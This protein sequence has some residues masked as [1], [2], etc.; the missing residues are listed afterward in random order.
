MQ[1]AVQQAFRAPR[2]SQM[3]SHMN[4]C[5]GDTYAREGAGD[6]FVDVDTG[7]DDAFA[8]S[9]AAAMQCAGKARL[10]GVSSVFGNASERNTFANTCAVLSACNMHSVRVHRGARAPLAWTR[11]R[12]PAEA[13]H[14]AG[15]LGNV[16][17]LQSLRPDHN[18]ITS[19]S[20]NALPAALAIAQAAEKVYNQSTGGK[21]LTVMCC[22][23]LTNIALLLSLYPDIEHKLNVV[24]M[25]GSWQG[26]NITPVAEWNAY[27]DP[28]ALSTVLCSKI[29]FTIVPMQVTALT[30]PP[31]GLKQKLRDMQL[32]IGTGLAECIESLQ[33]SDAV[34]HDLA[35][36]AAVFYPHLFTFEAG[37]CDV[38]C[39]FGSV[40]EGQTVF[41]FRESWRHER[42][43]SPNCS[44]ATNM[45][46]SLL[47]DA[48]L[49]N[50]QELSVPAKASA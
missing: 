9:H 12:P 41:D 42:Q 40:C 27:C 8:L 46:S 18:E 33:Q 48:F 45:Q 25:G 4:K 1:K 7:H 20:K 21:K 15:G 49:D 26:G 34:V 28:I 37:I 14:G 11:A 38:E 24:W 2:A 13:I 39:S 35:C 10:L 44:I 6:V 32:Q 5:S 17:T 36:S 22:A 23:G 50:L 16:P 31:D 29:D 47:W 30:T 43:R 19:R 3:K